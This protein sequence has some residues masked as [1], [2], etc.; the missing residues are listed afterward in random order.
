MP[1]P[2]PLKDSILQSTK[3]LIGLDREYAAFDLDIIT[4]INSA[5]STLYQAGVGPLE[6]YMITD[7][8]D[9]WSAFIGNQMHVND[10]KSYVYIKVRMLFDPPTTSFALAANEKMLDEYIWRLNVA[11]EFAIAA[12]TV[13]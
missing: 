5:F 7:E 10:V 8:N 2:I 12:A 4:H 1:D 3:K 11:A 6:G 9:V 13:E